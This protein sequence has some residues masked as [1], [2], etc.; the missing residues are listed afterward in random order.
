MAKP[1]KLEFAGNTV[2]IDPHNLAFNEATL[3]QYIQTESGFY[4]NFGGHLAMAERNLQNKELLL[5]K[6]YAE[7]F[8]EAK[9]MGG[10]DKL[11]EAKAKSDPDVV[12]VKEDVT[13]AKYIVNRLKQHLRA[14][15]K[16]H[17]N[18]QSLGHMLRKEM[19][20]LNAEI[21]MRVHNIDRSEI[22]GLDKAVSTTVATEWP[23]S[24]TEALPQDKGE[25]VTQ[26]D[27][28]TEF[29]TDLDMSNLF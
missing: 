15:D 26:D 29:E 28:P 16:N 13:E 19:D 25:V 2:F 4:D 5:E 12:A 9:E 8:V 11:A 10:S 22:P 17:D 24:E 1:E 23:A 14:W 7:R 3:T 21:S 27:G 20:K 18:A 6:I